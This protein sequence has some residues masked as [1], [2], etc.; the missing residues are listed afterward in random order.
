MTRRALLLA[1]LASRLRADAA[2]DAWDLICTAARALT[3]ATAT[4]PPDRGNPAPFLEYFDKKMP[5]YDT[6]VNN[7]TGLL[8]E[9]DIE[10][11]LDQRENDGDDHSRTVQVDWQMRVIELGYGTSS[12]RREEQVKCRVEKQGKKWKIVGLEPLEF[13]APPRH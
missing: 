6:L 11:T 1:A 4:P 13:F 12:T 3:E 10:C 8:R 7:V 9:D 5:G 2:D